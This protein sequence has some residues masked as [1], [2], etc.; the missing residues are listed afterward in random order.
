MEEV[1]VAED[2]VQSLSENVPQAVALLSLHTLEPE[3]G[4][5]SMPL[6]PGRPLQEDAAEIEIVGNCD[7]G[8]GSEISTAHLEW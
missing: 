1:Y 7:C 5:A 4:S 2:H 8:R 3:E 6:Q